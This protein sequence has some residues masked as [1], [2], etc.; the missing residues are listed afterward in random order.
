MNA[1]SS[2][3]WRS[4]LVVLTGSAAAQAI[5]LVGS[6][7]IARL[8]SPAEFGQ[9]ATWLGIVAVGAVAITGRYEMALAIE[10]D[11][12]PRRAAARATLLVV[13][14]GGAVLTIVSGLVGQFAF[15]G[16]I[17]PALLWTIG[18]AATVV[19]AS[20]TW[21]SWAAADGNYRDL[22]IIRIVQA[23]AITGAQILAGLLDAPA[24]GLALA[25]MGGATAGAVL[26]S[27]RLTLT[28]RSASPETASSALDFLRRQK[29]FPML[30][31]PADSVNTAAAQLPL[32]IVAHRFG[33]DVAGLLA[34]TLRI[35]GAPIGLLGASV[36]DVF[37]RRSAASFA[38]RG[39]CR[40]EYVDTF[41]MLAIG[42]GVVAVALALAA[43]P[44]FAFAFGE[45]WRMSGTMAAWLMPMFAL[46]FVASPLSYM[47]YVAGKQHLDLAWQLTLLA[48]TLATLWL[49]HSPERAIQAYGAGY[50]VLYCIY[51][52]M[53]YSLSKGTKP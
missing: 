2:G 1:A 12:A 21:Q 53:S 15:A 19:A 33:A 38:E 32:V 9:F 25:H 34:L 24:D 4:V 46:R 27:R 45:T 51:L 17:P 7:I 6:L 40:A 49:P 37:R 47:F 48:T 35:V 39:E 5:P 42:S 26:A 22:G 16:D 28:D 30:A 29:R 44:A 41:R 14:G 43:E 52:A 36:L 8:F 13:L 50:A 18:P 3:F 11:G 10:R 20:Q 31:L 23:G